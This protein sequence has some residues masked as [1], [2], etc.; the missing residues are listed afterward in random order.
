MRIIFVILCLMLASLSTQAETKGEAGELSLVFFQS[1]KPVKGAALTVGDDIVQL[2][3]D[4]GSAHLIIPSGLRWVELNQNGRVIMSM[5]LLTISGEDTQIIVSVPEPGQA[6]SIDIETSSDWLVADVDHVHVVAADLGEGTLSGRVSALGKAKALANAQIYV[7]GTR[8]AL[9]TDEQGRFESN[10]PVGTYSLSVILAGYAAVTIDDVVI[11]QDVTSTKN[12]ELTPAGLALQEFVVLAP[13]IEGSVASIVQGTRDS[14]E[15]KEVLGAEQM[16]QAGDSNAASALQRVTGLTIENGKYVVIR[17]QPSRYTLTLLNGSELPSPDPIRRVVPL[18]LFPTGV[19]AGIEVQK[20]YSADKPGSFGGGLV[21]LNLRGVPEESFVTLSVATAYN[22]QSTGQSGLSYKGGSTDYLG[23]DDGTRSLPDGLSQ[24]TQGG[25]VPINQ[26]SDVQKAAIGRSFSNNYKISNETLSPDMSLGLSAGTQ[27]KTKYGEFGVLVNASWG[28]KFR[29]LKSSERDL[30]EDNKVGSEFDIQQTTMSAG[31]G[32]MLVLGAKW[33]NHELTSNRFYIRDTDMKIE[34]EE[35]WNKTSETRYE[36]NYLLDWNQREM[37]IQ[38]FVG[39]HHFKWFDF[40]WRVLN[41]TGNRLAPDRRTY[42]YERID[43]VFSFYE[44]SG[45]QRRY[46]TVEDQVAS[47][48]VD[49]TVPVYEGSQ[50]GVSIQF[51]LATYDQDRVSDT[52]RYRFEPGGDRVGDAI[53]LTE[54]NPE[55]IFT[56]SNIGNGIEF[57][58]DTQSTDDYRGTA[59]IAGQYVMGDIAWKDVLRLNAGVRLESAEYETKTFSSASQNS[60]PIL[61]HFSDQNILPALSLTWTMNEDMQLRFGYSSTVSRPVLVEL[62]RTLF[63]DPNSGEAYVGNPDLLPA[64]ISG[65]DGRWEWYFST[66]EMLSVGGFVRNYIN[67]IERNFIPMAGGGKRIT[68]KNADSA[69]VSGI[70]V[71]GRTDLSG[72]REGVYLQSNLTVMRS[73]V[74][75][76]NDG[77]ATNTERPLQGQADFVFNVQLGFDGDQSDWSITYNE[78]GARLDKAGAQGSPDIYREPVPEVNAKWSWQFNDGLKWSLT[79]TNLLNPEYRFVGDG[80]VEKSYRKGVTLK[81][82][83]S[84]DF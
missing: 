15:V 51:G 83:L 42:T 84:M 75:L 56:A 3:N 69:I 64:E 18:D 28:Q 31:A 17:G 16:S 27:L 74:S 32:A 45:V 80:L 43:G 38:Q 12:I 20:S 71:G 77:V 52:S 5:G 81:T 67:P 59:S 79:G 72:L 1:G 9:I 37:Q 25:L 41:A 68:F 2:T 73:S 26:L 47:L 76:G 40:D 7:S 60:T 8:L 22:S 65:I 19:L 46:N 33:E 82:S 44:E 23:V 58:D 29:H 54:Q 6:P 10:L 14:S 21:D 55:K 36:R 13:Y 78:V 49:F 24:G 63:F 35:G 70:E 50:I 4:F 34:I 30:I 62:S 48:G 57:A 39:K 11:T 66:D 61:G 53:D